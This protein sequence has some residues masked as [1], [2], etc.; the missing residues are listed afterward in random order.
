[1]QLLHQKTLCQSLLFQ[2]PLLFPDAY[3]RMKAPLLCQAAS[4][5]GTEQWQC[6]AAFVHVLQ[7]G[8][9][10]HQTLKLADRTH[11]QIGV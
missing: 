10:L 7:P 6:P 1:M 8:Q 3:E 9:M 11:L 2:V 4:D 5:L